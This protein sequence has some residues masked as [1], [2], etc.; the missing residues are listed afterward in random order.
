MC[1]FLKVLIYFVGLFYTNN[2][3]TFFHLL[4]INPNLVNLRDRKMITPSWTEYS[5]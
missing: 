2:N 1:F 4:N 5:P 3:A